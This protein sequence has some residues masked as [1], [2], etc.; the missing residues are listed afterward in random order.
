[1]L[2]PTHTHPLTHSIACV[3]QHNVSQRS[4]V[5]LEWTWRPWATW[6]WQPISTQQLGPH[7]L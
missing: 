5:G 7:W 3:R 4:L 1:M 2:K 6:T